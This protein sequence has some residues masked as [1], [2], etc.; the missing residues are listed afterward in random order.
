[1]ASHNFHVSFSRPWKNWYWICL[2]KLRH[3]KI[4]LSR[5][6]S[7][8]DNQHVNTGDNSAKEVTWFY[9][10]IHILWKRVF[11]KK[12]F[13]E[14]WKLGELYAASGWLEDRRTYRGTKW[15][16]NACSNS[17]ELAA[18]EACHHFTCYRGYTRSSN[19]ISCKTTDKTKASDG[20][21]EVLRFLI[22]FYDKPEIVLLKR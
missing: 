1:M 4:E 21:A 7:P 6:N 20:F 13:T 5:S 18:K 3:L 10:K 17:T 8:C 12:Q 16:E 22:S 14:S 2:M 9:Q 11:E 19:K 15:Y